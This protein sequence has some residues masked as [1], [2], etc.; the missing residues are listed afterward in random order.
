MQSPFAVSQDVL[1]TELR[2]V[3]ESR[4]QLLKFLRRGEMLGF[5]EREKLTDGSFQ[6]AVTSKGQLA[7][8][9]YMELLKVLRSRKEHVV[10]TI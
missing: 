5:I 10:K 9:K 6:Y 8:K 2:D 3:F 4:A 7:L 1:E